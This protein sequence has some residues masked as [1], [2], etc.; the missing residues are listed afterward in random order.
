[1]ARKF[2]R[3]RSGSAIAEF[4]PAM[5]FF[6]ILIVLPLIDLFSFG[7]G[8]G[9]TMMLSTWGARMAAPSATYTE[10]LATLNKTDSD[11]T[12]FRGFCRMIPNGPAG[13]PYSLIVTVAPINGGPSTTFT[14]P[15]AIPNQP[16]PDASQPDVPP[17]NKM[18][19]IYQY[20]VT[21]QYNVM[22]LFNFGT[23]PFLNQVPALGKPVPVSFVTTAT[24]EHPDGLNQ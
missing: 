14:G 7:I 9:V 16:P 11:L 10:A 21:A 20:V 13:K 5:W 18:N 24:V 2:G 17:L 1:M 22:P 15:G 19:A 4:G 6:L 23:M 8:V 12:C 3:R